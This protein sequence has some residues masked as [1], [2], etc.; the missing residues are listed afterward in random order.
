MYCCKTIEQAVPVAR[1][2]CPGK[3]GEP[4]SLRAKKNMRAGT[5]KGAVPVTF[6]SCECRFPGIKNPSNHHHQR[7]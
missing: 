6:R 5:K 4:P 1:E 7:E 3:I 2:V